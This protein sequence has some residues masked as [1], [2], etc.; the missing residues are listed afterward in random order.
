MLII[1]YSDLGS[2]NARK[3]YHFKNFE[4]AIL[5]A[6]DRMI[7]SDKNVGDKV[8]TSFKIMDTE[9]DF[10]VTFV[11]GEVEFNPEIKFYIG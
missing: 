9:E 1:P 3:E 4:K 2:L 10:D 6:Y 11:V 7:I 8:T 5:Y